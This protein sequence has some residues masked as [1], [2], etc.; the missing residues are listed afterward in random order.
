VDI[1]DVTINNAAGASAVNIQDG[2]NTITVDGTVS[3][4]AT[5]A[6]ETTK[7]IGTVNVAAAQTIA[8]TNAGTFLVQQTTYS[9]SS[10]TQVASS[11]TSV[12]LLASTAGRKGAYFFNDSTQIAYIKLGTTSATNSYTVKMAAGS[13][14]E[15]PYPCYTGRID[16]IWA[17]ANGVMAI[18][19]IT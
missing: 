10:V 5:L 13:F 14:Y 12:Q 1:G 11:A 15:L 2:G 19:E 7:V 3:A 18:T 4:N 17:S 6:A 9:T 16:C 8:T